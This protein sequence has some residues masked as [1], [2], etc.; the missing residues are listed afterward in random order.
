M[1]NWRFYAVPVLVN[2]F[3]NKIINFLRIE[4]QTTLYV[5]KAP[6]ITKYRVVLLVFVVVVSAF[7]TVMDIAYQVTVISLLHTIFN[8][9]LLLM[10]LLL[11]FMISISG[12][13]LTKRMT[14]IFATTGHPAHL[15]FVRR[16]SFELSIFFLRFQLT[17]YIL[18]MDVLLIL[19]VLC[20]IISTIVGNADRVFVIITYT[21]YRSEEFGMVFLTLVFIS[22][23]KSSEETTSENSSTTPMSST[24]T[25][26]S[27]SKINL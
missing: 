25:D 12:Y 14:N 15:L 5:R 24:F 26:S 22:R 6:F 8:I 7:I 4:I 19:T 1:A 18:F 13:K 20:L 16:V 11:V 2:V 23:K 27:T 3:N 21:I 17:R 9:F 10:Y